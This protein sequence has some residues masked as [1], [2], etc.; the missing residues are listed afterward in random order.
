MTADRVAPERRNALTVSAVLNLRLTRKAG[1]FFM[2]E[3]WKDVVNYGGMYKVSNL[4]NVMSFN[5]KTEVPS[6]TGHL[7]KQHN[8]NKYK[9]VTLSKKGERKTYLVHRLVASAFVPNPNGYNEINHIDENPSNNNAD[10]LEWCTRE[11]N[12]AY[13]TARVRQGIT[14]GK[15]IEQSTIDNI[16]IATYCSAE[17]AS[18][19]S[20]IDASS[21]GKCC[22][23]KRKYAGGYSWKY[24]DT[25]Y[26]SCQ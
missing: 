3:I 26:F 24:I 22:N 7:L 12:M 25:D 1:V 20:G 21:I 23:N 14:Y 19:I 17:I 11:Y 5:G 4:G 6:K 10:N 9:S 13:G 8:F 15:P 2:Q 16:P 18:K